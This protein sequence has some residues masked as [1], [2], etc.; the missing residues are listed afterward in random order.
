[1]MLLFIFLLSS[2]AASSA[3]DIVGVNMKP[4]NPNKNGVIMPVGLSIST[5]S[6]ADG[7]A[8]PQQIV[9]GTETGGPVGFMVGLRKNAKGAASDTNAPFCGGSLIAPRIVLTA[10]N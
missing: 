9:G 6:V 7:H 5:A 1:M 2:I 8:P 3:D 4:E 10:A